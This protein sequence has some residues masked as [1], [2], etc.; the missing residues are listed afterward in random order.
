MLE[1]AAFCALGTVVWWLLAFVAA[2]IPV[3]GTKFSPPRP[4][5]ADAKDT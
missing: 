5:A 2:L 1:W 3:D 4:P